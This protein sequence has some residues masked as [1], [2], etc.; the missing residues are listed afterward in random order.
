M[1]NGQKI[2]G[3]FKIKTLHRMY[4]YDNQKISLIELC[5]NFQTLFKIIEPIEVMKG[6][7]FFYSKKIETGTVF[8][9]GLMQHLTRCVC[10]TQCPR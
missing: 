5:L 1:G 9:M 3:I 7:S 10:E 2:K 8:L 4:S 6:L